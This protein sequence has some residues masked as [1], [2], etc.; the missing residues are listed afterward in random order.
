MG[1]ANELRVV[2]A[3]I[4]KGKTARPTKLHFMLFISIQLVHF[5]RVHTSIYYI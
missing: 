5:H 4:C 1:V 3:I 2:G